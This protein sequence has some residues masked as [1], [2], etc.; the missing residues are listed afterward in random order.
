MKVSDLCF[1]EPSDGF[2]KRHSNTRSEPHSAVYAA[3]SKVEIKLRRVY[4]R[5]TAV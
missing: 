2:H 5:V 4:S 3:M 1:N